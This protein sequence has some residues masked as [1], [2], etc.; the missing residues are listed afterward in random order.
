V[1]IYAQGSKHLTRLGDEDTL[2]GEDVI[3]GFEMA[4]AQLV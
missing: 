1:T 4:V 2:S 3:P